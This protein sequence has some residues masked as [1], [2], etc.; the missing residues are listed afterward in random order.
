MFKINL[1]ATKI[2]TDQL[3]ESFENV[4]S[5]L[6]C[7]R[8]V[9]AFPRKHLNSMRLLKF[10]KHIEANK[11]PIPEHEKQE[12][13]AIKAKLRK[14]CLETSHNDDSPFLNDHVMQLHGGIKFK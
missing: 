12:V 6:E 4:N 7:W 1:L 9:D 3:I 14:Y 11:P 5:Q 13:E 2:A 10:E 8:L